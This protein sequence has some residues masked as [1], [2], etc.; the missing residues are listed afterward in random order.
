MLPALAANEVDIAWM[1]EFPAVTGYSN[2]LPL[3]IL[4]MERLDLTNVRLSANRKASPRS[5]T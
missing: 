4:F 2:G 3:E 5:P 1:G